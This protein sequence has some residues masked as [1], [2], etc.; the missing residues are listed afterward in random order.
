MLWSFFL[1]LVAMQPFL[2]DDAADLIAKGRLTTDEW[3]SMQTQ[4]SA[5]AD[6]ARLMQEELD[7]AIDGAIARQPTD[8]TLSSDIK[9][10]VVGGAL[11]FMNAILGFD[12]PRRRSSV[13]EDTSPVAAALSNLRD[14]T[15]DSASSWMDMNR[16]VRRVNWLKLVPFSGDVAASE[17]VII[18][19][20]GFMSHGRDPRDNWGALCRHNIACY[21]VEWEAGNI[22]DIVN[23]LGRALTAD[24][25]VSQITKNPWNSAQNKAH[26]VGTVLAELLLA[27][28]TLTTHR[29]VTV[30]GHSLGGAVIASLLDHLAAANAARDPLHRVHLH[31]VI[32]FA[33]AFVPHHDFADAALH[34]FPDSSPERIVNVFSM[35]DAILKHIFRLGNVHV[36]P[37]AAGC[38]GVQ[39]SWLANW[40]VTDVVPVTPLTLLGHLYEA[41]MI[42]ILA[43]L[44][45]ANLLLLNDAVFC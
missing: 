3:A 38:V 41:H 43:Q 40:D 16:A 19:I 22:G 42:T 33:A 29:K 32:M 23:C 15:L 45:D 21:A 20:D 14:A 44:R 36:W 24:A 5:P 7:D 35:K 34:V 1:F 31:Q 4:A 30:V 9:V 25:L 11:G 37:S 27:Q 28:P 2:D 26:Q 13:E 12:S 6:I 18:T 39:S 10:A 17:H 8:Q